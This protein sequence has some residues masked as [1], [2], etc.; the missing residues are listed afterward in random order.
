[1]LKPI[2]YGHYTESTKVLNVLDPESSPVKKL[3]HRAAE[4]GFLIDCTSGHKTR[5]IIVQLSGSDR[6]PMILVLC[7]V[8]TDTIAV[9]LNRGSNIEGK[10]D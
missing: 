10:K 6:Y 1:M 3:R 4:E 5:S 2:G 7:A 9:R 8:Q